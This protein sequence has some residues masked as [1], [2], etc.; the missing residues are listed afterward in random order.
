[1]LENRV[2]LIEIIVFISTFLIIANYLVL[3]FSFNEYLIKFFFSIFL[4]SIIF[5]ILYTKF[6]YFY[7]KI[8]FICL[9]IISLG[10]ATEDWDA[11][12]VWL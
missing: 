2:K 7:L 1:M 3:F 8:T 6:D 5:F 10:D 12:A 9:I 11:W 4:L